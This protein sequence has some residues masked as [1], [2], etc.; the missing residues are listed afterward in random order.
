MNE[1]YFDNAATTKTDPGVIESMM[2]WFSSG[3]GNPSSSH[4]Q[5]RVARLAVETAR[6]KIAS[7]LNCPPKSILFTSGG[8]ESANIAIHSAVKGYK[9]TSIITSP[10]E[11][12]CVLSTVK[13]Y[14]HH[15]QAN[16]VNLEPIDGSVS[17]SQLDLELSRL[18]GTSMVCLMHANNE[19]GAMLDLVQAAEICKHHKAILFCDTVATMGHLPIDLSLIQPSMCSAS[20][21]KFHGPKGV[22]FLY[23][24]EG[25]TASRLIH[26]GTQEY[27][28]RAGT[29][30]VAGIVGLAAALELAIHQMDRDRRHVETIRNTFITGLTAMGAVINSPGDGLYTILNAGFPADDRSQNLLQQLDMAGVCV[31]GGSACN[32]GDTGSH[33]MEA[34]GLGHRVNLRFSFSR[35]NSAKDVDTCLG[36]LRSLITPQKASLA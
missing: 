7:L 14:S 6:K 33:V 21:H 13:A 20:A 19:T 26:G 18:K 32:A 24:R 16:V 25:M 5:G 28:L 22:G 9:T 35:F 8:T 11:H 31:S 23:V 1:I 34:M 10:L 2:P 29:E 15:S 4:T 30:N 17:P 27:G 12:K 3:Y 36:L